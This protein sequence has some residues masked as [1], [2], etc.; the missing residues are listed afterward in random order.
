[1]ATPHI[2]TNITDH[3]TV[4]GDIH[5]RLEALTAVVSQAVGHIV[6]LGDLA[7]KGPGEN[8]SK[9]VGI[10]QDLVESGRATCIRGNHDFTVGKGKYGTTEHEGDLTD[11]QRE[12]LKARPLFVRY[13]GWLFMHG[14][15]TGSCFDVIQKLIDE[16]HLPAEGDWTPEMVDAA[17]A[18]LS[19]KFRKKLQN[20]MYAR[21]VRGP[22]RTLVAWG[23]ETPE[24]KYWADYYKGEYGYVIFGHNPWVDVA[25]FDHAMG[26]DLGAG[27]FPE[28]LDTPQ[29][30]MGYS[31]RG[32]RLCALRIEGSSAVAIRTYYVDGYTNG[33]FHSS[34]PIKV[35]NSGPPTYACG[36][37]YLYMETYGDYLDSKDPL[38]KA[39]LAYELENLGYSV[40]YPEIPEGPMTELKEDIRRSMLNVQHASG[41]DESPFCDLKLSLL[42]MSEGPLRLGLRYGLVAEV[43]KVLLEGWLPLV[44]AIRSSRGFEGLP[45]KVSAYLQKNPTDNGLLNR[46]WLELMVD[47]IARDMPINNN[48]GIF[49]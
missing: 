14:G 32:R 18:S 47:P 49:K 35:D 3:I 26:I 11:E 10:V 28:D 43:E 17:E 27:S 15:M 48:L 37:G 4:I 6:F 39:Y 41:G 46:F 38:E 36:K 22:E 1:M 34:G 33:F 19:S 30:G 8:C 16:G 25:Y 2:N 9:V 44:N 21:Y 24:D 13:N 40:E 7:H 5:N 31:Y 45:N 42:L 23:N 12:W 20:C 29:H